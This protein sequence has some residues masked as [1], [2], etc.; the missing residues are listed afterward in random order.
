M[1]RVLFDK[2]QVA[3]KHS[4]LVLSAILLSLAFVLAPLVRR[5]F[6]L[7][8]KPPKPPVPRTLLDEMRTTPEVEGQPALASP[9][10][11]T[12][13]MPGAPPAPEPPAIASFTARLVTVVYVLFAAMLLAIM[14]ALQNN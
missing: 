14:W 10:T 13:T 11:V 1:Y 2:E 7:G 6:G 8:I 3:G 5:T 9:Q 4:L 12:E